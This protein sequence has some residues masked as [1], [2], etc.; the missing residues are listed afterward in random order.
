MQVAEAVGLD[1]K[2]VLKNIKVGRAYSS[3]HQL[4]L[5]EKIPELV[6]KDNLNL[7]IIIV[8]SLIALFRAEYVGRGT[9]ADRQQKINRLMHAL[10]RLADRYNAAVYVTNQV[11]AR[12]DIFFGDPTTAVGGNV[13]G[14]TATYR[15][16]LR[17]AKGTKRIARLIDSPSLPEGEAVFA[18]TEKGIVDVED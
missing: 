2:K 14:H 9:L 3:D 5:V 6:Q 10:Q 4:L 17:K 13:V 15:L 1:P 12:P 7:K 11:M 8:D 18:V 16:Y